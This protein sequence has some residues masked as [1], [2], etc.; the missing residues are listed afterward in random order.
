VV[1]QT[2]YTIGSK[3]MFKRKN[4]F[5]SVLFD[6][7]KFICAR[8]L[9]QWSGKVSLL[10]LCQV[11]FYHLRNHPPYPTNKHIE[12]FRIKGFVSQLIIIIGCTR[13][14]KVEELVDINN[15]LD[16]SLKSCW[17]RVYVVHQKY[18][19]ITVRVEV[20]HQRQKAS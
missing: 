18:N 1:A 15:S 2:K 9:F 16:Q 12:L 5:R 6:C 7:L 3:L 4:I 10:S 19:C 14:Y 17:Y 20:L 13:L 8:P 11:E